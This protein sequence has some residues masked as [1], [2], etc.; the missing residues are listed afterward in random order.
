MVTMNIE[1][2]SKLR[3]QIHHLQSGNRVTTDAP[4]DNKGKGEAFSP[5]DLMSSS[6]GA[7][8]LTI[9]GIRADTLGISIDGTKVVLTKHMS[10]STPRRVS[11]IEVEMS[12]PHQICEKNL[13]SLN[14][15]ALSC[16]V[17]KSLHPDLEVAL[18]IKSQTP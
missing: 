1:Y 11:K 4:L 5:T 9:M 15:V 8:M 16:P 2:Q 12:I 13:I 10:T 14:R 17:A 6:L 7:C 18:N 3:T